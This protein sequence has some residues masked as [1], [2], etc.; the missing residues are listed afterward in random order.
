MQTILTHHVAEHQKKKEGEQ[1]PH[2]RP[3]ANH[4]VGGGGEEARRQ[5]PHGNEIKQHRGCE[6]G[7]GAVH[8]TRTF[9]AQQ[10]NNIKVA[11]V[12]MMTKQG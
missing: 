1:V 2:A 9:P 6:V 4:P 8:S 11:T 3:K 12:C 5:H 7:W 10:G